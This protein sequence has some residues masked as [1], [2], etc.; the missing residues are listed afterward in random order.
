MPERRDEIDTHYLA[1][2]LLRL[3]QEQYDHEPRATSNQGGSEHF[4]PDE[5]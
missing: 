4:D 1:R 5:P 3:A 2:A